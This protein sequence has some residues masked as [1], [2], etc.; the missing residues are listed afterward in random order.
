M[1]NRIRVIVVVVVVVRAGGSSRL[2]A[3]D[4]DLVLRDYLTYRFKIIKLDLES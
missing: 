2:S 1:I 3:L 4:S